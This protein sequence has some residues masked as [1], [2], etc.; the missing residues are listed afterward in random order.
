MQRL[1]RGFCLG[2]FCLLVTVTAAFAQLSTAQLSGRVADQSG[3][4]RP[5]VTVTAIQTDT[6]V[7]RTDV[8]D[9]NG[10]YVLPNLPTGPYRLQG[11]RPG[12]RP[13]VQT[14]TG[15]HGAARAVL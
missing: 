5:G 2:T 9:A 12:F 3:A 14:R 1:L 15:L 4:V 8:T 6:G 10:S 13:D 11:S 7:S